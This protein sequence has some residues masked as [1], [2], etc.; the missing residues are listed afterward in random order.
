MMTNSA[1]NR[2][3]LFITDADDESTKAEEDILASRANAKTDASEL[4]IKLFRKIK[5]ELSAAWKNSNNFK[6]KLQMIELTKNPSQCEGFFLLM[7]ILKKNARS[8]RIRT[9]DKTY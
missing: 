9:A 3:K 7:I 4:K 5:L 6:S 8:R 1:N 2:S